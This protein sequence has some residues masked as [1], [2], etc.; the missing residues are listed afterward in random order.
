MFKF[1]DEYYDSLPSETRVEE[2]GRQGPDASQSGNPNT[3]SESQEKRS[4]CLHQLT[5]IITV[6]MKLVL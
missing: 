6:I 3:A 5:A 1:L 2:D 4:E